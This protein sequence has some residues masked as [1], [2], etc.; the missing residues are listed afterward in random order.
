MTNDPKQ[1]G[2]FEADV[3]PWATT[4]PKALSVTEKEAKRLLLAALADSEIGTIE[5]RVASILHDFPETRD[6]DR[7]LVIRYWNVYQADTVAEWSDLGL[8]VIHQLDDFNTI[9][10]VRR[11]I[12]NDLQLFCGTLHTQARRSELQRQFYEYMVSKRA[13]DPEIRFYFDETGNEGDK[14]YTGIAGICVLDWRQYEKYHCALR[15]WREDR[16]WA[17]TLHFADTRSGDLTKHLSLLAELRKWRAGLLF[18]G[19]DVMWNRDK[20][21]AILNLIVQLVADSIGRMLQLGCLTQPK[22]V[23]VVKEADPGFDDIYIPILKQNL[24]D[25]LAREFPHN[26]YVNRVDALPKGRE[27]LLECAD[28][29]AGGMQRRALYAGRR[30]KDRLAEAVMNVTG[31]EDLRDR[32]ALY[33]AFLPKTANT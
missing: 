14:R 7:A 25:R 30:A 12:Q 16:N 17:E 23:S 5:K 32:G 19:H 22:A 26:V 9:T 11:H 21:T 4:S 8:E 28:L 18:I 27:V 33:H 13:E 2:L 1:L 15:K 31:F 3:H 20:S 29:I 24:A 10:R 6:S